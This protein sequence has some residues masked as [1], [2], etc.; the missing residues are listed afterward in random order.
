MRTHAILF[1]LF[2]GTVVCLADPTVDAILQSAPLLDA[3]GPG[4]SG[5][6]QP[7][8]DV[9]LHFPAEGLKKLKGISFDLISE[10]DWGFRPANARA[11]IGFP[12]LD[13][14]K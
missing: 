6:I 7:H 12:N 13:L 2:C 4:R 8:T 5:V 1:V 10:P 11:P 3:P 14:T 9:T